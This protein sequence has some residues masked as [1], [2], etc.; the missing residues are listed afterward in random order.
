ME[1]NDGELTGKVEINARK[2]NSAKMS[3][4]ADSQTKCVANSSPQQQGEAWEDG[5]SHLAHW[6]FS[7]A[8][9]EKKTNDKSSKTHNKHKI[10][11]KTN[12]GGRHFTA[13]IP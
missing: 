7:V 5:Y 12:R 3:T 13:K 6:T 10:T 11:S 9:I 2:K 4:S 1:K 8:A